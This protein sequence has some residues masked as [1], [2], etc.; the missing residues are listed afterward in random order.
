MKKFLLILI[1]VCVNN[2][3][4]QQ[5]VSY[6]EYLKEYKTYP[7]SDPDPIPALPKLYPYFRFDGFTTESIQKKWKVVELENEYIKVFIMPEIGGKIWT[8]YDKINEKYFLYNNEVVKFRD[9]ALRGPWV[10]GGIEAN[11]GVI[12]HTPNSAT[13]VD[14][15]TIT[16][17]D[18]SVSCIVSVLDLLT[19]TRWILDIN[20]KKDNAYFTTQS[21]WF[22]QTGVEQPYYTWMNVGIPAGDDL[23]FLYPG[24]NY[25]GH[26][27]VDHNWQLNSENRDLS[28]YTENNFDGSKS[29]HVLGAHSKY[30]G[31]LWKDQDYGMIHYAKRGDKL[32]KKIF[33]W[34]QSDQGKIWEDLLTDTSGQYVEI[35]SGRLFNQNIPLSSQTPFKQLGFNS[36]S[37]ET[38]K[39]YWYPFAKI[40]GFTQASKS[41]AFTI[42]IEEDELQLQFSPVKR[43]KGDLVLIDTEGKEIYKE[44]IEAQP[45]EVYRRSISIPSNSHVKYLE[46]D[47]DYIDLLVKNEKKLSRPLSIS[48]EFDHDSY[49]ALYLEGRDYYR[50]RDYK[51]AENKIQASLKLN[52]SFIPS[53]VEMSKIKLFKM[54][55]DSAFY[56]SKKALSIDTYN[57]DANYYYGKAASYINKPYDALDGYEVAALTPVNRNAA[58]TQLS[59]VYL[60]IG[61]LYEAQDYGLRALNEDPENIDAFKLLYVIA[62]HKEDVDAINFYQQ[63]INKINPLSHFLK[64]ESYFKDKSIFNRDKFVNNIQNEMPAETFLELAMWYYSIGLNTE[65]IEVL[66]LA[67]KNALNLYWLSYLSKD[68]RTS[69]EYY[70]EA[71]KQSLDFVFPFREET[72]CMLKELNAKKDSWKTN[73]LLA[74]IHSFKGNNDIA[75]D[76]LNDENVNFA[77]YYII[78]ERLDIEASIN[79]KMSYIKKAMEIDASQ[80]RYKMIYSNLLYKSGQKKQ[81]IEILEKEY[82]KNDDN[83]IVGLRLIK[84]LM[85]N[86]QYEKAESFLT[87]VN[88][89]PFE[90]ATDGQKYYRQT[91]LMLAY[92]EYKKGDYSNALSKI[93]ESEEW[94]KTLGVGKPYVNMI[95]LSIENSMRVLIYEKMKNNELMDGYKDE[96][97]ENL[98]DQNNILENIKKISFKGDDYLF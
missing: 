10:S 52:N 47:G 88:V 91:K 81:A 74:L 53:L 7:F 85:M 2:L 5:D 57:G 44:P 42:E 67:P 8:A 4:A 6:K 41:G 73:Y 12:G 78:K 34:A 90:G 80:W 27:G 86:N 11:Y 22:N 82:Y 17:E 36:Y 23:R 37:S 56:Y 3:F 24:S 38:W 92:H 79:T 96:L 19:R 43:I 97:G 40:K 14:Y 72:A 83:Y 66:K 25:I 51:M 45:L 64:F 39:E 21:Y 60:K 33:L 63:K 28:L 32:G 75:N 62:R 50:F 65:S 54:E 26:D 87:N 71:E 70:E 59:K 30:F 55:Y 13:P 95:D 9:I 35:Q 98:I 84:F 61:D 77:P 18:G 69:S 29:Y 31:A 16:K 48:K 46:I 89:L 20:L 1:I 94:P 68:R 93:E 15:T 58:Y 49:Y 76:L